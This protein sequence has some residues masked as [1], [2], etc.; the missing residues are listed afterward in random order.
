MFSRPTSRGGAFNT[1]V[2]EGRVG[3]RKYNDT[4]IDRCEGIFGE[5]IRI[6]LTGVVGISGVADSHCHRVSLSIEAIREG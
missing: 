3:T 6:A 2:V 5:I 4:D 1:E